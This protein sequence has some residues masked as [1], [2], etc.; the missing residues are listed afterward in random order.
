MSYTHNRGYSA[1]ESGFA[2]GIKGS[3]VSIFTGTGA[4]SLRFAIGSQASVAGSGTTINATYP[5]VMGVYGDDGNAAISSAVLMRSGRFRTLLTYTGGNR[6]QEA[7]GAIGQIVSVAGTNRHNMAGLMGSYEGSG[8]LTIDGQAPSTDPWIQA[9]VIG[10]VGVGS[11]TTTLNANGR[12]SA[13]AAMCNTAS[14]SANNGVFAGLYV[15]HWASAMDFPYGVYVED[16]D[17]G[18]YV[19]GAEKAFYGS[20]SLSSQTTETVG[21]EL[22]TTTDST[23]E[24][25]NITYSGSRGSSNLKLTGVFTGAE[26]GFHNLYSLVTTSGAQTTAGDGVIGIKSVV[27][28]SAAYTNGV[29]YGGMFIAKHSHAT[30][31]MGASASLVGLEAW[32]YIADA[33]QAATV[34]GGNFA[35]HNE[36]TGTAIGGSVHRVLQLVCDNAAGAN[37]A[38][39]STGLCIWNMAGTW[40]AA[41]RIT[42]A[43]TSLIDFTD[44]STCYA[45]ITG[46]P[47]TVAGQVVIEMSNGAPG[48]I[49]VYSTSGT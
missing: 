26:G 23:Y 11:A 24:S 27:T 20:V 25:G 47:T 12:L 21:A 15:G 42:G 14:F 9:G 16:A 10:R 2:V 33:G 44:A 40:D 18:V 30:N 43:F 4:T 17:T 46:A 7:V 37:K 5:V 49:T 29:V 8:A 32:A 1:T 35:I 19:T 39:E 31:T 13:L 6:E 22:S 38:T 45:A 48:Y 3:E 34:I 28:N 36:S 41:I